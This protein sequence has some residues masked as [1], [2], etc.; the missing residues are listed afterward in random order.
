[1]TLDLLLLI[2]ELLIFRSLFCAVVDDM[3]YILS[4]V[5]FNVSTKTVECEDAMLP[6]ED[7]VG[8]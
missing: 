7:H 1:M 2:P 8:L 4:V 5:M 6:V 3:F